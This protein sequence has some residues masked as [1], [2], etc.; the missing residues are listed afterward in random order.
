MDA[1]DLR[2]IR[3]MYPDGV[4]VPWG[5]DP[6]VT[7]GEIGR[8]I[9]LGRIAVWSRIRHWIREGFFRPYEVRPS[10]RLLGVGLNQA[11]LHVS[12]PVDAENVMDELE[13]VDGVTSAWVGFGDTYSSE[14]VERVSAYFVD[15]R[16]EDV[17]R[18]M[19][20]FRR[21]ADRRRV[22]GPY[23]FDPPRVELTPTSLDWRIIAALHANPRASLT[24]VAEGLGITLKTLVRR[25]DRL[26]DERALWY[27]PRF[28]WG[29]HP[30]VALRFICA[31]PGERPR[32]LRTIEARFESCLPLST[33]EIGYPREALAA[34]S[35][36]GVRVPARS[37]DAM[38]DLMI[39]L[40]KIPGVVRVRR[41]FQ[42]PWRYYYRWIEQAI[43]A[44]IAAH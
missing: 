10:Y 31:D 26:L 17:E 11:H 3:C 27:H 8:R 44:R 37:A 22:D 7:P 24:R 21:L 2:I 29:L 35:F 19:R 42:G 41:D 12:D 20:V 23:A 30:S 13:L 18:R 1:T 5:V 25:R 40:A 16:A 34:A 4:W 28:D 6:R 14:S 15:D 36:L 32:I 38:Q 9:G 43:A 39:D 33:D